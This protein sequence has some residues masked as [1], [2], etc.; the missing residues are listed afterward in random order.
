M[1][2]RASILRPALPDYGGQVGHSVGIENTSHCHGLGLSPGRG[3]LAH[4]PL[5]GRKTGMVSWGLLNIANL[6]SNCLTG[7]VGG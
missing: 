1:A 3:L 7:M 5:G 6:D 4:D 2:Q